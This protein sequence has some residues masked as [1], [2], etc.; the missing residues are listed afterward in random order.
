MVWTGLI[1]LRIGTSGGLL[2]T[3]Y[4]ALGF[5]K[6]LGHS[7]IAAQLATSQEGLSSIEL[8][9]HYYFCSF[10]V[11]C[12][13]CSFNLKFGLVTYPSSPHTTPTFHPFAVALISDLTVVMP[14]SPKRLFFSSQSPNQLLGPAQPSI[15]WVS[16]DFPRG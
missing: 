8:V 5:H 3:R 6:M 4:W 7:R 12:F 2:W 11:F 1:W 10:T 14:L 16:R 13:C 15:E 9:R